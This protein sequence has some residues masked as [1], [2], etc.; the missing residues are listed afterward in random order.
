M[1][2]NDKKSPVVTPTP[3]EGKLVF[4]WMTDEK[5]SPDQVVERIKG[6]NKISDTRYISTSID[7]LKKVLRA[8]LRSVN[9]FIEKREAKG[10]E[11]GGKTYE[12]KQKLAACVEA[13]E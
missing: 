3:E 7:N 9:A 8:E 12:N 10:E 5:L 4:K 11:A 2:N 13:C 1:S 6:M